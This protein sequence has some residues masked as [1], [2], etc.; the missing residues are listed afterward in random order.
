MH[1]ELNFLHQLG[2]RERC[3]NVEGKS[4]WE[5]CLI[6]D[7]VYLISGNF[8]NTLIYNI[9][10]GLCSLFHAVVG[11][12][13]QAVHVPFGALTGVSAHKAGGGTSVATR[14]C[15]MWNWS[16]HTASYSG[17]DEQVCECRMCL[18]AVFLTN[19]YTAVGIN[20]PLFLIQCNF[21]Q[22]YRITAV[23]RSCI[24]NH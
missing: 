7:L 20:E 6:G 24:L 3:C 19:K 16:S 2:E 15:R 14:G 13:N 4:T 8:L 10:Y 11:D 1:W 12:R 17:A 21:F 9:F 22:V 18:C 5:K 23:L